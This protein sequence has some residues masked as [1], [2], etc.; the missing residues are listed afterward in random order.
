MEIINDV[1]PVLYSKDKYNWFYQNLGKYVTL[2]DNLVYSYP[3]FLTVLMVAER[4]YILLFPFGK[5]FAN[6]KLWLYCLGIAI[7]THIFV[8][9]P[10]LTGCP[11]IFSYYTLSY[12]TECEHFFTYLFNNYTWVIPVTCMTLNIIIIFYISYLRKKTQNNPDSRKRW[13]NEKIMLS[14]SVACTTFLITYEITE[15][16]N[17]AFEEEYLALPDSAQRAIYYTRDAAVG[18]TCFFIYFVGTPATRN[19]ILDRAYLIVTKKPRARTVSVRL[20]K[21]AGPYSTLLDDFSYAFP[22]FLTI[23]MVTERFYVIFSPFG[24]AFSNGKLWIYCLTLALFTFIFCITPLLSGCPLNY[25][26]KTFNYLADCDNI[27]TYIFDKYNGFIPL[28]CMFLNIGLILYLKYKR[29]KIH[30]SNDPVSVARRSHEKTMFIQS[31]LS[32]TFL[33]TYEITESIIE[34]SSD[35]IPNFMSVEQ[36]KWYR[37]KFV[38]HISVI[39]NFAYGYPIFLTVLMVTERF[40]IVFHPFGQLFSNKNLWIICSLLAVA[41]MIFW[42]IPYFSECPVIFDYTTLSFIPESECEHI[43]TYIFDMYNWIIPVTCMLL[44]IGLILHLSYKRRESDDQL[45]IARRNHEKMMMVQ[46]VACT[47]FLLIFDI[48]YHTMNKVN[49]YVKLSDSIVK[50]LFHFQVSAIALLCFLIYFVGT[51]V[52]R[53]IIL[54]KFKTKTDKSKEK[55]SKLSIVSNKISVVLDK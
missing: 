26:F 16:I 13:K 45:S 38:I 41:T 15:H 44:N 47:L 12:E 39:D 35:V 29:R 33:L 4:V 52:T 51:P 9:T 32:T 42:L 54:E 31:V 55:K 17:S 30:N 6:G 53:R 23:V 21:H 43:L 37:H 3:M 7:W 1:L 40:Y 34:F 24:H 28:I 11:V 25:D 50:F 22:M 27:F 10:L 19:I 5:A 14:Q 2:V 49:E 36:Y 20:R 46:A 48:F 18:L 8:L